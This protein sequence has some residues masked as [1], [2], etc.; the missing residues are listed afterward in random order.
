SALW[1]VS[2]V[3]G[4]AYLSRPLKPALGDL[5][6]FS[7]DGV[8]ALRLPKDAASDE[9]IKVIRADCDP[10]E[11][12]ELPRPSAEGGKADAK[13][14][15]TRIAVAGLSPSGR[16]LFLGYCSRKQGPDWQLEMWALD[17]PRPRLLWREPPAEDWWWDGVPGGPNP[18]DEGRPA[19]VIFSPG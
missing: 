14:L 10:P 13:A 15:P 6:A 16:R 3:G 4:R 9:P 2:A 5:A 12:F 1:D 18:S 7:A 17:G 19:P 8:W 11:E